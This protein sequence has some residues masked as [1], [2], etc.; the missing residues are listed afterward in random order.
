MSRV[1]LMT[2]VHTVWWN[3]TSDYEDPD[4]IFWGRKEGRRC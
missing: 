1:I 4:G 2:R 3:Q